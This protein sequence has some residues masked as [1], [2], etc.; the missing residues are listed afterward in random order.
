LF[1]V[2]L[3]RAKKKL[4]LSYALSRLVFGSRMYSMPSEFV[5]EMD[6]EFVDV[7]SEVEER[8]SR[9]THYLDLE[10]IEF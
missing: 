9:R 5:T 6:P 4:F 8:S 7:V 3:T 1:Y 2:A 10:D